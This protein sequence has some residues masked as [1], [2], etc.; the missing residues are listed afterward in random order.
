MQD[1]DSNSSFLEQNKPFPIRKREIST[2]EEI[3]AHDQLPLAFMKVPPS[4]SKIMNKIS[5]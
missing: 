5:M 4:E 1:T 2:E 3:S